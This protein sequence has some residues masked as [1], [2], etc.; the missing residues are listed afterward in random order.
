MIPI[1][2]FLF[3]SFFFF[4]EL[5]V[6]VVKELNR[7]LARRE[8]K[9]GIWFPSYL[10]SLSTIVTSVPWRCNSTDSDDGS[11]SIPLYTFSLLQCKLWR[12]SKDL[13]TIDPFLDWSYRFLVSGDRYRWSSYNDKAWMYWRSVC[14]RIL[15]DIF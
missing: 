8:Q 4:S 10:A 7:S 14:K 3:L 9:P 12:S 5:K 13:W 2:Y 6:S 15:F 1:K 11:H